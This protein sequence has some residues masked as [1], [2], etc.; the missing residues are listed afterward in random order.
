MQY[1]FKINDRVYRASRLSTIQQ[2]DVASKIG[3][4]LSLMAENREAAKQNFTRAFCLLSGNMRKEDVDFAVHACLSYV[5]RRQGDTF[6]P[7][8]AAG[9]GPTTFMFAD[10]DL[11]E[12][13]LIVSNV[14]EHN[15]LVDFFVESPSGSQEKAGGDASPG[16]GSRRDGT[17]STVP[18][19]AAGAGSSR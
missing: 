18:S 17:G 6:A 15:G 13:L 8:L 16:Q 14:L 10:I 3:A 1:E 11:R 12:M 19:R 7:I 5:Q 4:I 9:G 2:F